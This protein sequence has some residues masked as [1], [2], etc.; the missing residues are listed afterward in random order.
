MRLVELCRDF[1]LSYICPRVIVSEISKIVGRTVCDVE[2]RI[3]NKSRLHF[4]E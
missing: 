1:G 4:H 3:L 2:S